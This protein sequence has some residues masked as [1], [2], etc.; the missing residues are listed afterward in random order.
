MPGH[1]APPRYALL[2][3]RFLEKS[4]PQVS[5][6]DLQG[7]QEEASRFQELEYFVLR[8]DPKD[9]KHSAIEEILE[10]WC[11]LGSIQK[12]SGFD[13][14]SDKIRRQLRRKSGVRRNRVDLLPKSGQ[15]LS[16]Q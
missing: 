4:N 13:N 5:E 16:S 1:K 3:I 9:K 12:R 2:P 8:Y 11:G 15:E 7:E 10:D 14:G 6:R